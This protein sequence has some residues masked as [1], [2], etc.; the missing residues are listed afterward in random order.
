VTEAELDADLTTLLDHP[1]SATA[2]SGLRAR[3]SAAEVV[4]GR[5]FF[6]YQAQAIRDD[7]HLKTYEFLPATFGEYLIARLVT[8]EVADLATDAQTAASRSRPAV[9]GDAFLH[10]LLR[11][12]R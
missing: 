2:A 4:V 6:I 11:T 7:T 12:C 10:A 9:T 1:A 3:L 8:R 5:F